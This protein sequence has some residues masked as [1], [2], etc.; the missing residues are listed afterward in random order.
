MARKRAEDNVG[1]YV[2]LTIYVAVNLT[3][4]ILWWFTGGSSGVFPWFIPIILFW[5][6]GL[7]AQGAAVF[8]GSGMTD[9]MA[10]RVPKT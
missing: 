6:I 10:E 7:V 9:K 8:L 4:V 5:G 3:F 1:F 2:H